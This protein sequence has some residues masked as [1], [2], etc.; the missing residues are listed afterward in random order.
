MAK[1]HKPGGFNRTSGYKSDLEIAEER[2]KR[3]NTSF[4]SGNANVYVHNANHTHEHFGYDPETQSCGYH[5]ENV[6]TKNNHPAD[7]PT[8]ENT[9]TSEADMTSNSKN[10]NSNDNGGSDNEGM[11]NDGGMVM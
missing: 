7:V 9:A 10:D 3:I 1:D 4:A 2:G 8:N 11:G 6:P 5:G